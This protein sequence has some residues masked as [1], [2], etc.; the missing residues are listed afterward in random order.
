MNQP[1]QIQADDAAESIV[2]ASCLMSYTW[3]KKN[4]E[5]TIVAT[6]RSM[7]QHVAYDRQGLL[8]P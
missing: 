6:A 8:V 7:R 4:G 1:R 5:R 2:W 3:M